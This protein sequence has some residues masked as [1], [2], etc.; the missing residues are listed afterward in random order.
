MPVSSIHAFSLDVSSLVFMLAL[1]AD[2]RYGRVL[3]VTD[4]RSIAHDPEELHVRT[5]LAATALAFSSVTP[6][7]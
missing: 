2:H 3:A 7:S 4:W 1:N 6:L 5:L